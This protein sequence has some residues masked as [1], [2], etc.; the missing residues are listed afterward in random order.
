MKNYNIYSDFTQSSPMKVHGLEVLVPMKI[1]SS[2]CLRCSY[3]LGAY[4][5]LSGVEFFK[6]NLP[7]YHYRRGPE[8]W[9]SQ[10]GPPMKLSFPSNSFEVDVS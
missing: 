9:F 8:N 4:D 10:N 3:N 6:D 1:N 7:F 2:T 5:R